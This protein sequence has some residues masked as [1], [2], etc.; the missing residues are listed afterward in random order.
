MTQEEYEGIQAVRWSTL[1]VLRV[2][3]LHYRHAL[4]S[5][6][7]ETAAMRIGRAIHAFIL[8]PDTFHDRF[9]CYRGQRR[10]K[11]WTGFASDHESKTILTEVEWKRAIGAGAAVHGHPCALSYL[12]GGV[13]EHVLTWTDQETGIACK[14]RVDSAG[15]W[16]V[17][18]KTTTVIEPRRFGSHAARL[19]VHGQLSFY[20]DGCRANDI[21]VRDEPR[22]VVVQSEPPHDVVVYRVSRHVVDAGRDLYRELLGELKECRESGAWPGVSPD[23]IELIPPDWIYQDEPLELTIGGEAMEL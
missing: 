1:R 16:L 7:P 6:R 15:E 2:S 22:I 14:G 13:Q 4:R 5:E 17:D 20:L 21:L 11:D 8:E 12:A 3:P 18:L 10:G 23:E 19:G 9:V